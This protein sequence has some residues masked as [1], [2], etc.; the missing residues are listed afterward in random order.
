[1]DWSVEK[2]TYVTLWNHRQALQMYYLSGAVHR[3]GPYKEY[4]RWLHLHSHFFLML[5]YTEEH[6]AHLPDSDEENEIIDE[7]DTIT[8]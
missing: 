7:Y 5:A 8:R 2:G 4:L 1:V 3:P 6:I